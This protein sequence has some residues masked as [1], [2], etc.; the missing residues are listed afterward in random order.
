[1]QL[2]MQLILKAVS[3]TGQVFS[4]PQF[5][6]S[7][8]PST[9]PLQTP[10][11]SPFTTP[12][13]TPSSTSSTPQLVKLKDLSSKRIIAEGFIEPAEVGTIVHH[14]R[15]LEFERKVNVVR[16][17]GDDNESLYL[18]T[19]GCATTTGE[20]LVLISLCNFRVL[21]ET[22]FPL[23][24]DEKCERSRLSDQKADE[25]NYGPYTRIRDPRKNP[26]DLRKTAVSGVR[27]PPEH[28][29]LPRK[30]LIIES[31]LD[32]RCV[33][34]RESNSQKYLKKEKII[35]AGDLS[36]IDPRPSKQSGNMVVL[37][38]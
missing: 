7:Y 30:I 15:I 10:S 24:D 18:D 21:V 23:L 12:N 26:N 22:Q 29:K 35:I 8:A 28:L 20:V 17:L 19:Q 11:P 37:D 33:R 38:S 9:R 31:I 2:N 6:P 27:D 14:R 34:S 13:A 32:T 4:L 5:S 16:I 25:G 3:S 1:M 36:G